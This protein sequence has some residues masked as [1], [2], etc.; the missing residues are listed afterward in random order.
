MNASG[1]AQNKECRHRV[2]VPSATGSARREKHSTARLV[3]REAAVSEAKV[4]AGLNNFSAH[5]T[6]VSKP[7]MGRQWQ[8]VVSPINVTA[9]HELWGKLHCSAQHRAGN[10]D[11]RTRHIPHCSILPSSGFHH[12]SLV[13][14]GWVTC[15]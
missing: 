11:V 4:N 3:S 14:Q 7:R 12:M 10:A 8:G 1:A 2:A 5:S 6:P 9:P 15:N 13:W